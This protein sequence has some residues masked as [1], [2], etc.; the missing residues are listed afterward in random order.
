MFL[1][2]LK[3]RTESSMDSVVDAAHDRA[4]HSAASALATMGGPSATSSLPDL[5]GE[6]QMSMQ[7]VRHNNN[8]AVSTTK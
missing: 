8:M 7:F 5:T 3:A 1:C 4:Q 2:V 6:V